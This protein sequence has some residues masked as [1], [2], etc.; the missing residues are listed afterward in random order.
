MKPADAL[1]CLT[2]STLVLK[3]YIHSSVIGSSVLV[4][5]GSADVS[6]LQPRMLDSLSLCRSKSRPVLFLTLSLILSGLYPD[7][8][9]L[10]C[11][12]SQAPDHDK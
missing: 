3:G 11:S 10:S 5:V 8:L 9:S 12:P 1:S 2:S 6:R 4:L 7:I